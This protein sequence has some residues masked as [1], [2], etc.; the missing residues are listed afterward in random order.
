[1]LVHV[2][3]KYS[4]SFLKKADLPGVF[5]NKSIHDFNAKNKSFTQI[6]FCTAQSYALQRE[7]LRKAP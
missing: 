6:N 1:M 2:D 5:L 7:N 3:G 4:E